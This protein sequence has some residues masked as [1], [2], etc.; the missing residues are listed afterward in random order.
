MATGASTIQ[1]IL[2]GWAILLALLTLALWLY[3]HRRRGVD[4]AFRP[5]E[6]PERRFGG[7][8]RR[9]DIGPPGGMPDRRTG[10]D[11]RLGAAAAV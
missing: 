8:R 6:L 3:G 7:D 9:V 1:A 5:G 2:G 10:A 11:R 4:E